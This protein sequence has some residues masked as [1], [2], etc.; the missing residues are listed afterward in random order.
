[1]YMFYVV[2]RNNLEKLIE[3]GFQKKIFDKF[4]VKYSYHKILYVI[5]DE[6][7]DFNNGYFKINFDNLN[8]NNIDSIINVI[9]K[10]VSNKIL[11]E[12]K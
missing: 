5:N 6:L 3:Y 11:E 7:V 12:Y 8:K 10:L 2:N 9:F 1:M 4:S